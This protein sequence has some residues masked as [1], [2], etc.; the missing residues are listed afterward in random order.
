MKYYLNKFSDCETGIRVKYIQKS[1][2]K[3]QPEFSVFSD[4]FICSGYIKNPI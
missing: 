2:Q 1:V 3:K 4:C